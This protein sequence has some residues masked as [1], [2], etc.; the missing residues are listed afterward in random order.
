MIERYTLPEIGVLW[1]EEAKYRAWLEVELAVCR[2]RAALG[3]IP[4]DEVEELAEK[5]DFT[6][7]RI[8]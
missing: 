8:H 1:G 3:E 5:A 4:T 2:A 6:L 7:E